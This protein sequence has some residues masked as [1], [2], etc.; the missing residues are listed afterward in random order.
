[1]LTADRL[2]GV[3]TAVPLFWREDWSLDEETT[4]L[5]FRRCAQSGVHGI[6]S[7][8]STGEYYALN[9]EEFVMV[10]RMLVEEARSAGIGAQVGCG[11]TNTA[12]TIW[13]LEQARDIGADGAQVVLPHWMEVSNSEMELFWK[14]VHRAVPDLPLI[15][16]NI[17]RA[18]RFLTGSDYRRVV[19]AAPSMIG[20]KFANPNIRLLIATVQAAPQLSHFV[21]EHLLATG[22]LVGAR[23]CYSA[24][25]LRNPKWMM[26]Y[27]H[28]CERREWDKAVEYQLL[29]N[30]V[31]R[32]AGLPDL[33]SDADPVWDKGFGIATGFLKG[34][35]RC[36]PPYIGMSDRTIAELRDR[37]HR[38]YPALIY[39]EE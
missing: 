28:A 15:H 22:M 1:M 6:Y 31:G 3:W 39:S 5:N 17:D 2:K 19:E 29:P 12:D 18:K 23:G 30:R 8:G 11:S 9:R 14:T 10:A 25:S 24:Y 27:W 4:R 33:D 36:R 34:H 13:M 37:L 35:P 38:D 26:A 32:P 7:T 16:Y 20:T 21:S